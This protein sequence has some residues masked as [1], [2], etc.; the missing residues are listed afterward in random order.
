[1]GTSLIE[2]IL[3]LG[4]VGI[5]LV[6]VVFFSAEFMSTRVKADAY[7]EVGW[8]ARFVMDRIAAE[9][10]EASNYNPGT[11]VFVSN[12]GMLSL[13]SQQPGEDPIVF[14]VS[15]GALTVSRG[16]GLPLPLTT[17]QVTVTD[18]TI[19]DLSFNNRSRNLR[20][21]LTIEY[22]KSGLWPIAPTATYEMTER[23]RR[24][25]GVNY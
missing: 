13:E 18:F 11:S 19:E 6:T 20:I 7:A 24:R 1:M 12:P 5:V 23:V 17:S 3:Y 25:E 10:R 4:L 22:A 8:N 16:G 14:A 9:I 21:N 2:I 15:D